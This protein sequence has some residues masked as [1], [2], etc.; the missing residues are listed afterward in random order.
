MSVNTS[1]RGCGNPLHSWRRWHDFDSLPREVRAALNDAP[2]DRCPG[3]CREALAK[4]GL[5]KT[6][7]AIMRP[8]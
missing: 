2:L 7:A 4:Y 1:T 8:G 3:C 6:I 5:A